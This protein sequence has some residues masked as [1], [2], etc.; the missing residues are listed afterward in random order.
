MGFLGTP[1]A[2]ELALRVRVGRAVLILGGAGSAPRSAT[3][4]KKGREPVEEQDS[5]VHNGP[6]DAPGPR[7]TTARPAG[8]F[9]DLVGG[10]CSGPHCED[11]QWS[12]LCSV[13]S[14]H[15]LAAQS[16]S[17]IASAALAMPRL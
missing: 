16:L 14:V 9:S 11:G 15:V 6:P 17:G 12:D 4:L 7:A 13:P 3:R 5:A 10:F 2:L 8:P 1:P